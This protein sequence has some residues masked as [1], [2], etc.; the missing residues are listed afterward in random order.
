[1]V[2]GPAQ[3]GTCIYT[4][5]GI[6]CGSPLA[7]WNNNIA[8]ISSN[9]DDIIILDALMGRQIAT[10]SGHAEAIKSLTYSSDGTFLVSGSDDKTIKL[11]DVQTGGV[12]K[13]FSHIDGVKSVSISPDNTMIISALYDYSVCL[14]NIKTES[15]YIIERCSDMIET[16]TFSPTNFQ[17]LSS[18]GSDIVQQ[19]DINGHKIGSQVPGRHVA[20]SPDG[21]QLASAD[22]NTVTIRNTSS[23]MTVV[24]FNLDR[25]VFCCCF[26]PDGRVIATAAEHVIYLWDITGPDPCLIQTL[27]GHNNWINSLI[28]SS[29]YNLISAS[30]DQSIKFWQISASSADPVLPNSKSSPLTTAQIKCVSLQA[31]DGLAFSIDLAGVV[32]T[33]DILTGYCKKSYKTEVKEIVCADIQLISDRLIIVGVKRYGKGISVWDAEKGELQTMS[34][35]E[36]DIQCLRI[37]GDGPRV[38]VVWDYSFQVW[39]IWTGKSVY[40]EKF[41]GIGGELDTLRMD[42]KVLVCFGNQPPRGWDFGTPGSAPT[43]F[44]E[45]SSDRPCL[46]IIDINWWLKNN[47]FRIEDRVTGREVFQLCGRYAKPS[48]VQWD[49]RY[50]IAGYHSGKVLILDLNDVLSE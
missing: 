22:G 17:F 27:L 16:V 5:F 14:W 45:K 26:S 42:A 1:M 12:I 34:V 3:W 18:S 24:E 20:F 30:S 4:V 43:V 21:T 33:W 10:L 13:T 9:Q 36:M 44:I 2:V 7:Y 50:L 37:I 11:W 47:A 15:C 48:A 23:M 40:E 35:P 19:W 46:D 6:G 41:M 38:A 31:R 28:F 32:K 8:A 39:D 25:R 49:G 29:P